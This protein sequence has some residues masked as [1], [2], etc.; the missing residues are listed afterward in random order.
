MTYLVLLENIDFRPVIFSSDYLPRIP[1]ELVEHIADFLWDD[2]ATLGRCCLVCRALLWASVYHLRNFDTLRI[3]SITSLALYARASNTKSTSP[4]SRLKCRI[5]ISDKLHEPF[6]HLFPMRMLGCN[7]QRASEITIS[8]V[9]WTTSTRP[10]SHFF[11]CLSYYTVTKLELTRC[12]FDGALD[13][14]RMINAL[15]NLRVLELKKIT[16]RDILVTPNAPHPMIKRNRR[17][18]DIDLHFPPSELDRW[19]SPDGTHRTSLHNTLAICASQSSV[20]RLS[21][22]I[23]YFESCAHLMQFIPLISPN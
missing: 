3:S 2:P 14:R 9:D 6:V 13:I 16:V 20:T 23:D 4:F 8:H 17:L 21:L 15:S 12:R 10:H 22:D 11:D 18:K 5:W 7:V 19:S 1:Q